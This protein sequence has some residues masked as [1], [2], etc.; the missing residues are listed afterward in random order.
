MPLINR[1]QTD[2]RH[3]RCRLATRE[4]WRL[5]PGAFRRPARPRRAV[6][7]PSERCVL[8]AVA[9]PPYRDEPIRLFLQGLGQNGAAYAGEAY[10]APSIR[11]AD[12]I[13]DLVA[14]ANNHYLLGRRLLWQ[15]GFWR[16]ALGAKTVVLELNPRILSSWVLVAVRRVLGDRR[17]LF[18]GHA[19]PRSGRRAVSDTVRHVMRMLGDALLVY[20]ETQAAELRLQMPTKEVIAV[21][22]ALYRRAA[23]G[24]ASEGNPESFIYVGRLVAAKKPLLLLRAFASA[25]GELPPGSRMLIV[26]DGPL[27]A[28]LER[29]AAAAGISER[30]DFFGE[31]TDWGHLRA[32]YADALASVSPGYVGLSIIQSLG[33]GVPMIVA[34]DESHSPELEAAQEGKNS[35][36]F[37]SDSTNDLARAL[38]YLSFNARYWR[39][40]RSAIADECASQYSVEVMVER[41]LAAVST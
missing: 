37:E 28:E 11:T 41:M 25:I 8:I 36:M 23:M 38:T 35:L 2:G 21:P 29:F 34:R 7:R 26:G 24:V 15:T 12:T 6:V 14:T 33:F 17:N 1:E 10:F 22:N 31:V 3:P 13:K 19:W 16:D 20:T 27:R 40:R 39:D 30:V 5:G 4:P 32:L 9:L 18:W